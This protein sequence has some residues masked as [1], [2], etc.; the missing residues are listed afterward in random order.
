MM[1]KGMTAVLSTA[2]DTIRPAR[3]CWSER[4]EGRRDQLRRY[5]RLS[6]RNREGGDPNALEPSIYRFILK[7]SLA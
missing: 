3:G 7:H 6:S 1:L 5:R 2:D 4:A